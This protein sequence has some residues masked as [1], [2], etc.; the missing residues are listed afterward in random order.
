MASCEAGR[1]CYFIVPGDPEQAT[2]GYRYVKRLAETLADSGRQV[3]RIGLDGQFPLPDEKARQ[4]MNQALANLP[5]GAPVVLDGLAMGAM[6][7]VLAA[8]RE[9][10]QL[11][12]LVHHPLADETGLPA[13]RRKNLFRL[14]RQALAQVA[15]VITTSPYTANRLRDF[16]VPE[17]CIS[18]IEPGVDASAAF[19]KKEYS[20][21]GPFHVLCVAHLSPRKAQVDLLEAL[22]GLAELPWHLTLAGSADRDP[23]YGARVRQVIHDLALENRVTLAGEV[24][25]EQLARLYSEAHLFVL[26]SR[27]EGYGMVVDEAFANG[28]PVI[29]SDGGALA[30]TGKRP[31]IRQY[32]A[33]NTAQLQGRLAE[34]L[35]NPRA[36]GQAAGQARQTANTLRSWQD[37]AQALARL[38][39][40]TASGKGRSHF[41]ADW[42]TLREPEDHKARSLRLTRALDKWL[43][44]RYLHRE[45]GERGRAIRIAD[46]GSGTGSNVEY[47]VSRLSVP[48]KWLLA[49]QDP[50]L[51]KQAGQRAGAL[52]VAAE[53]HVEKLMPET[54]SSAI[55]EGTDLVT[56]AALADLVSGDW[57]RALASRSAR[58]QAAVLITLSVNGAISLD[59]PAEA[60]EMVRSAI[61]DHQRRDKG[62]GVAMGHDAP[63]T[64]ASELRKRGYQLHTEPADWVLTG[65]NTPLQ[66]A[67]LEGWK[68]AASEQQPEKQPAIA[69][70]YQARCG[71]AE[72]GVLKIRV[73]HTDLLALPESRIG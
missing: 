30:R 35:G 65:E 40:N 47:L 50:S 37:A 57:L 51:L 56:A 64:L 53:L 41:A 49:D 42:L 68:T 69:Q 52:G 60:D 31:G 62:M 48:Q 13:E 43:Q 45:A 63:E 38:L 27:Y 54:L 4:S 20:G 24:T 28:L 8:H 29:C 17:S 14:E 23:E 11:I 46:L 12:A 2:G 3:H 16:S 73:G 9:R 5:D 70:W 44:F 10:L 26:P 66:L 18:V 71:Q 32:P 72:A 36:M 21:A 22:A 33:G 34:W 58:L 61:L 55:P 6:P 19:V 59:P 1:A 39:D 7:E 25:G 15:S 67:L